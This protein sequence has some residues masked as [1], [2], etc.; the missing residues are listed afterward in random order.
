[1][2]Q[3][4]IKYE[5]NDNEQFQISKKMKTRYKKSKKKYYIIQYYRHTYTHIFQREVQREGSVKRK[6]REGGGKRERLCSFRSFFLLSLSHLFV[7]TCF[8]LTQTWF[9]IIPA[10]YAA[11]AHQQ[12]FSF[13]RTN[14]YRILFWEWRRWQNFK[15]DSEVI[16]NEELEALGSVHISHSDISR[17]ENPMSTLAS[18]VQ[19][20]NIHISMMLP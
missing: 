16:T 2:I 9:T 18:M 8:A 4:F 19:G 13:R 7:L 14:S 6:K 17:S 11:N 20:L 1:M 12:V 3:F 10:I 5:H 15:C